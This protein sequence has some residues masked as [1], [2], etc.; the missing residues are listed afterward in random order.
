MPSDLAIHLQNLRIIN[1]HEHQRYEDAW[2]N[3]GPADVLQDLFNGYEVADFITAGLPSAQFNE[4]RDA[5]QKSIEDRWKILGPAWDAIRFTGY[6]EAVRFHARHLYQIEHLT[7]AAIR[8]AQ[9]KLD[10]YRKPGQRVKLLRDAAN[11]DHI[12]VDHFV[13]PALPDASG[14]DFFLY[15]LSMVSFVSGEIDVDAV[16][17]ETGVE[18]KTLDN[19][20]QAIDKLFEKYG[21]TAIAVK[22]QHAYNR[23]LEWRK[24]SEQEA[25]GALTQALAHKKNAGPASKL[26]LG[27]WCLDRI[28]TLCVKHNLPLKIHTGY[29]AGNGYLRL[30]WINPALLGGLIV[31]HPQ[32]RFV[33]MHIGYP[34]QQEI[35]AMAKQLP[36]AFVDLCWAWSIDPYSSLDFVR[37][38]IHAVPLNKIFGFGGDT[39]TPTKGVGYCLQMRHWFTR[40]LQAEVDAGDLTEA[41]AIEVANRFLRDNQ[42]AVFDIEGRRRAIRAAMAAGSPTR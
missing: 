17:K 11:Q 34:Y 7:A 2:V 13:W 12:Q 26:A 20:G 28:C 4:T 29:H 41:D 18:V 6:G 19:L 38:C 30:E 35:A 15:D 3:Q 14:P 10:A 8:D 31:A 32:T 5:T 37:R 1:T 27:N 36:N 23:S 16:L 21:A 40:A 42:L 25:A 24:P 22:T 39:F 33:L 9:P